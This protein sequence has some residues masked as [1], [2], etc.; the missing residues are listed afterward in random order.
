MNW[1]WLKRDHTT[2]PNRSI[3][4]RVGVGHLTVWR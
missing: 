1:N 4:L 3:Y 2:R